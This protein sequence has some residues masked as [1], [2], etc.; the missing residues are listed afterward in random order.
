VE[1]YLIRH[2]DAMD[3]DAGMTDAERPLSEEGREKMRKGAKGLRNLL[4][5]SFPPLDAVLTSPL[6]RAV[7]SAR[8]IAREVN[9]NEEVV[10]CPPLAEGS[11]WED[12]VPFLGKYPKSGRVALVGHEPDLGKL[13]GWLLAPESGASIPL[14]KGAGICFELEEPSPRPQAEMLWFLTPKQLRQL[15]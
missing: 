14:K 15:R 3:A 9:D 5:G 6:L 1:I 13:A 7:E 12:L 11:R 8:I 10:D 4:S 2:A